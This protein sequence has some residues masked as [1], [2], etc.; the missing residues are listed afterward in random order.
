MIGDNMRTDILAGVHEGIETILV[1][2]GVTGEEDLVEFA[3]Q[4]SRIYPSLAEIDPIQIP[5]RLTFP[6]FPSFS[7]DGLLWGRLD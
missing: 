3:Y 6:M 1:M 4:P 7:P 5:R 2:S